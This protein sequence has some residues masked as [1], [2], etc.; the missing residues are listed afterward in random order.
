V[1]V[2]VSRWAVVGML[3]LTLGL[4]WTVL[5]SVAWAAMIVTYSRQGTL[6]EAVARTFDGNHPCPLCK[7]VRAGKSTENKPSAAQPLTK[8]DLFADRSPCFDFPP[9]GEPQFLCLFLLPERPEPPA[10]PPPRV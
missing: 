4:H 3:S 6:R 7:L 2:K 8:I 5:Q 10:L 9:P 1:L